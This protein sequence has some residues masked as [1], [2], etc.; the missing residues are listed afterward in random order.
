VHQDTI[1]DAYVDPLI[2]RELVIPKSAAQRIGLSEDRLR[3]A[4]R[5]V[6]GFHF[7]DNG[8]MVIQTAEWRFEFRGNVLWRKI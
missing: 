4:V 1:L 5:S 7:A 6:R 8:E 3:A 2:G